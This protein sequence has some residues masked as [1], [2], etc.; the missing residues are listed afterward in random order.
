MKLQSDFSGAQEKTSMKLSV[1]CLLVL[2]F[3]T[4]PQLWSRAKDAQSMHR[5]ATKV[6]KKA[7]EE[8]DRK[9][10]AKAL[11]D[12]LK[13]LDGE[14]AAVEF[15]VNAR[16]YVISDL[17]GVADSYAGS[18]DLNDALK[19]YSQESAALSDV[20]QGRVPAVGP[21]AREIA[22]WLGSMIE[23]CAVCSYNLKNWR[24]LTL[25]LHAAGMTDAAT[26]ADAELQL[27]QQANTAYDQEK[28]KAGRLHAMDYL[29][30]ATGGMAGV[31]A[32]RTGAAPP[33]ASTLPHSD[34]DAEFQKYENRAWFKKMMIYKQANR[35]EYVAQVVQEM[36]NRR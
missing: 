6:E 31:A 12:F 13:A 16:G 25:L 8:L 2:L 22:T 26:K 33:D 24:S 35:P 34:T 23:P 30:M 29:G 20:Q 32:G 7:R 17:Q 19:Y 9:D 5:D 3:G 28:K 36:H 4:A 14:N 27:H 18:G 15:G 11:K 21:S 1:V 10:Y